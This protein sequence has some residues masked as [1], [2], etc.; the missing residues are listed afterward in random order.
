M[1]NSK[2]LNRHIRDDD[3]AQDAIAGDLASCT[4][5]ELQLDRE[6]LLSPEHP[7]DQR[8]PVRPGTHHT[9]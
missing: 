1:I 3:I 9:T 6:G 8:C 4:E 7:V 5:K 2:V